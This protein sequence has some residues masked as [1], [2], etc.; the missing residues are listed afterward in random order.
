M[1]YDPRVPVKFLTNEYIE[2][3]EIGARLKAQF[4]ADIYT[5]GRIQF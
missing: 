2:A 1:E 4:D 5:L 3:H